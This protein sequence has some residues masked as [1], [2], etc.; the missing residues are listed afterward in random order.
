MPAIQSPSCLRCEYTVNPIGID[1]LCPRFSWVLSH[2][3]RGR[4]PSAYQILVASSRE[5]L[6]NDTGDNWDS[7]K[8]D[9]DK[10]VN[11]EYAGKPLESTETYYWKVRW[12]DNQEQASPFSE[13]ATFEVGLLKENEWE[14]GWIGGGDLLRRRFEVGR[15][16][17][18]ARAYICGLGNYE[19]RINGMKVGDHELDPGW[20]DYE[21]QVLYSA[22][23]ITELLRKGENVVGVMLGNGRYAQDMVAAAPP[24]LRPIVKQYQDASPKVIAQLLLQ[25]DDGTREKIVTDETWKA[26]RGPIVANDLYLGETYDARL[27]KDGWDSPGYDDTKWGSAG[28]AQPPGGRL[29]SQATSP[30]IKKIKTM[31]PIA[32]SNPG[33]GVYVYDFG[34]NFAGW[35]KLTVSGPSGVQVKLRY[36]ELLD[37]QGM[38]NQV[39]LLAAKA[40]DTYILR[41]NGIEVYEPRFTYHGFRYLEVTGFPGTPSLDSVQGIVVHSAVQPAGEFTCSNQMINNI[42]QNVLWTQASNLMSVPTDCPQRSERFGWMGDAQLT[43][44]EATYN[45]DMAGFYTKWMKDIKESQQ[46]DGSLPNVAPPYWKLYPAEAAW[47]SACLIIPWQLFLFYDDARILEENYEIMKNWLDFLGTMTE[48]RLLR[49]GKFGDWCPPG[50]A[51]SPQ[52]YLKAPETPIELVSTWCYYRDLV[53]LSRIALILKKDAQAKKYANLAEQVKEAFNQEFL[54]DDC[55]GSRTCYLLPLSG[56]NRQGSQ[57]SN[58]LTLYHD[59][60]PQGKEPEIVNRLLAD[61]EIARDCHAYTGIVGTRFIL[62]TLTKYARGDL[63]YRLVTQTTYPGWGYM[64]REGATTLWEKWEHL[65]GAGMNS[66]NHHAFCSVDAWFYK[67]LAGINIDTSCP[68]FKKVIIKPLVVGDL[69]HVSAS[70]N[71]VRGLV[72]SSWRKEDNSLILSVTLPVNTEGKVS[73]PVL[74]MKNPIVKEGE[75]IVFQDDSFTRKVPGVVSGKRDEG[76]I[77]F[78]LGS[79]SY[80]LTIIDTL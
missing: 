57:T 40:T 60:V 27:E 66:H 3:E 46:E 76:Y 74:G 31:H 29:V 10:S 50:E 70:I 73:V 42:H 77:T 24:N 75:E 4:T 69:S 44:E 22:Y 52:G 17:K 5:N 36:A 79:G 6:L 1:V 53:L 13:T 35:A 61:I 25:F 37:S 12:W 28:E 51:W 63:A 41:G 30:P 71:T 56:D 45:F 65:A 43:A 64:I 11:V 47:A 14:A 15:R 55:Y 62:D 68:G 48:G 2:T 32:L 34:Q 23:D 67:A 59:M 16:V 7:G 80:L 78:S 20:T 39:P 19:L 33:P 58:L 8:V 9:S 54:K 21:K 72:A 38:I 49:H 26:S 18:R